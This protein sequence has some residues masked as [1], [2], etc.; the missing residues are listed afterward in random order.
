MLIM[1]QLKGLEAIKKATN[2]ALMDSENVL[3]IFSQKFGS[4]VLAKSLLQRQAY[5]QIAILI[6]W[7]TLQG[8]YICIMTEELLEVR[9]EVTKRT[10]KNFITKNLIPTKCPKI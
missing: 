9:E 8:I 10:N 1:E 7:H 4:F 3:E 6:G 5:I 2:M